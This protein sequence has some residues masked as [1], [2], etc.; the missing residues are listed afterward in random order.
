MQS[1]HK[2]IRVLKAFTREEP[3]LSLT[4]LNKKT[5]IGIS[6][7]QRFVSTLVYEGFLHKDERT[8]QYQLGLSLMVLGKLVEEES[9]LLTV[10]APVLKRLNEQ[11]GESVALNIIDGHERRCIYNLDSTFTL[12]AKTYV[13]DTAPLHAGASAKTL[14]A[15]L[16]LEEQKA[17]IEE[18]ELVAVTDLTITDGETLLD[19]LAEIRKNGVAI[20]RGERVRGAFSV[21]APILSYTG[22][23]IASITMII[24][25]LRKDDYDEE[26]LKKQIMN[27]A[28][29]IEQKLS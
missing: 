4:E 18:E 9:S 1:L 13:G 17:Y 25:D 24:P 29:E 14:L 6:S 27:A 15:F 20:S 8:K 2:A 26:A 28:R 21:S 12:T 23:P 3:R 7:L 11:V 22:R 19:N 5:G 10:A 16:T